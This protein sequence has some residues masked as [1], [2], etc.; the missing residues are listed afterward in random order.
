MFKNSWSLVYT[1]F[2]PPIRYSQTM[3]FKDVCITKTPYSKV[4]NK[5]K[6]YVYIFFKFLF[7]ALRSYQRPYV[8]LNFGILSMSYKYFQVFYSYSRPYIQY[9]SQ[10]IQTLR[11]F[12]ALCLFVLSKFPGPIFISY[13]MSISDSRV[14]P[15]TL[16]FNSML[17][18][19]SEFLLK[20]GQKWS[21]WSNLNLLKI[22]QT[23]FD[24]YANK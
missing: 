3:V 24:M 19:L 8:L 17:L 4:W 21:K 11:L 7:Q 2:L 10:N 14:W 1:C 12:K 9:F 6:P 13:P 20:N 22:L 18:L 16:A 23:K 15:S 5:H